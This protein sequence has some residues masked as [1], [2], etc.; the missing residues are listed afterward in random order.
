M[1]LDYIKRLFRNSQSVD[2]SPRS[3]EQIDGK[4][5]T[6]KKAPLERDHKVDCDFTMIATIIT[7][8]DGVITDEETV[9]SEPFTKPGIINCVAIFRAKEAFGM[10]EVVGAAFGRDKE[11][12][13]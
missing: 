8:T 2:C 4:A 3:E 13:H 6:Y 7:T 10:T 11:K 5:F 9:T 1:I 12:S